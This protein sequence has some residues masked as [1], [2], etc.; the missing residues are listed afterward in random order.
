MQSGVLNE[1]V[2][3]LHIWVILWNIVVTNKSDIHRK[4]NHDM[5]S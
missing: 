2:L 3:K 5:K 4:E 1:Q